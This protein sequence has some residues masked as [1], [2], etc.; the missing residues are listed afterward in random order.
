MNVIGMSVVGTSTVNLINSRVQTPVRI[1]PNT[2]AP[3]LV[4]SRPR[5]LLVTVFTRDTVSFQLIPPI[6]VTIGSRTNSIK[7][8][9][10][11]FLPF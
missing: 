8:L 9:F 3:K 5:I 4:P 7:A 11:K 10:W 6:F 1:P 2:V